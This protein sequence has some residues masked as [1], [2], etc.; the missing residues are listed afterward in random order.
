M[1]SPYHEDLVV[2][3]YR[4]LLRTAAADAMEHAHVEALAALGEDSR[5][6]L[7]RAVQ[8]GLVAGLRLSPRDVRPMAHLITLGERR[9]PGAFLG[10]CEDRSLRALADGV[11]LAEASFALFGGYAGWDGADPVAAD[12]AWCDGGFGE[13][14]HDALVARVTYRNF[15]G[16]PSSPDSAMGGH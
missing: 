15:V 7:L 9:R 8:A 6:A 12:D 14:W 5:A 1:W 13:R 2:R 10:A 16:G 11:V 4:Y 3:Q